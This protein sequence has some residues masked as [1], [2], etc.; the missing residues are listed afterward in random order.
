M[1]TAANLIISVKQIAVDLKSIRSS[2]NP[3]LHLISDKSIDRKLKDLFC[4]VK[5]I[6]RHHGRASQRRNL[7]AKLDKLFDI[8]ACSLVH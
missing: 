3:R 4:L 2:V 5:D 7:D 8:S 1:N 6:N